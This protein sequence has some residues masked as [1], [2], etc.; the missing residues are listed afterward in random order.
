MLCV[1]SLESFVVVNDGELDSGSRCR[2]GL[3]RLG[4]LS[5]ALLVG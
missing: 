5:V 4:E 2:F 3:C 1:S